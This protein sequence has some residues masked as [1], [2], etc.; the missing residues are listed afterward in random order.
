[1]NEVKETGRI[2]AFSDG[3]FAIAI[4]LLVLEL[5]VPQ[6]DEGASAAELMSGLL[7]DWPSYFAYLVSFATILIMWVSHH[8]LFTMIA[9]SDGRFLFLNGFLLL[10][11]STVP[12]PTAL[13]AD[14]LER[15][16][17]PIA[18][19]IYAGLHVV[20]ALAFN[21]LWRYAARGRRLLGRSVTDRQVAIVNR[22][23]LAGPILYLVAFVLAFVNVFLSFGLC[24]LLA[25][26]FAVTSFDA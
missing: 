11:V 26:F 12:F 21:G 20:L 3:V 19:A 16:A 14:Y 7:R 17:A 23:Y 5:K 9:R 4:T 8:R 15:P 2:E 6:L 10:L 24:A 18:M 13:L 22:S 1:M 25:I